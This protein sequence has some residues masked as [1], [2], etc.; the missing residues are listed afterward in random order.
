MT[1]PDIAQ[2]DEDAPD[3]A[4]SAPAEA[5]TG[6]G[7]RGQLETALADNKKLRTDARARAFT[8]AGLDTSTGIGK[9]ISQVYEGEATQEAV[10][11][12]AKEEYG[13]TSQVAPDVHPQAQAIAD[14]QTRID[15]LGQTAGSVAPV[16]ELDAL[17]QA[18]ADGDY[19]TTMEIKGQQMA[20]MLKPR[21]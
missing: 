3:A 11:E 19:K 7:L 17:A 4:A 18:E 15:T 2:T 6:K 12:F 20:D 9:A 8:D 10:T 1:T 21:R 13:W 5:D 14:E 16:T